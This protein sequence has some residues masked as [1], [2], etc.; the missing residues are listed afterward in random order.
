MELRASELL[1]GFSECPF[2]AFR[3]PK[4]ATKKKTLRDG[5]NGF[6]LIFD[7]RVDDTAYVLYVLCLATLMQTVTEVI[8]YACSEGL[9]RAWSG[10]MGAGAF[11]PGSP[12]KGEGAQLP[13]M[14]LPGGASHPSQPRLSL[15]SSLLYR[16]HNQSKKKKST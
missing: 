6:M 1:F 14:S 4:L 8:D 11:A 16:F 2:Q 15:N 5:Q 10:G 9:S 3:A 12:S 13:L 7:K